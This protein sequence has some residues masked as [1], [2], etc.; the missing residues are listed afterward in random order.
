MVQVL[1]EVRLCHSMQQQ[2][3]SIEIM[4]NEKKKIQFFFCLTVMA[5]GTRHLVP[6]G[7]TFVT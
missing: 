3:S 6:I 5:F 4:K 1:T 7:Y 2:C